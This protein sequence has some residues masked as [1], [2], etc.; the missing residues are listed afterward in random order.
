[1]T[2]VEVQ[3]I[4]PPAD[5]T[6]A[7][8]R[9]MK[10]ERDK[11]AAILDFEGVKQSQILQAEGVRQSEILR[12]E[13]DAQAKVLRATADAKAIELVSLA[14]EQFF[15]DRAEVSKKLDVLRDVLAQQ[16]KFIVPAG[17]DFVNVLGLDDKSA[18]PLKG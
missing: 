9:Q 11:R 10:A 12:A 18:V 3:K 15:K 14:A 1:M 5:I 16:S 17:S 2:R 4:D 7:M 13:G 6:E 8:S